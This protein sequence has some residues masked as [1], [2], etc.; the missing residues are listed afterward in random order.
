M[1]KFRTVQFGELQY[2]EA[3]VIHLP[4]GLVGMP[5]L[6]NWLILEMGDDLPLSIVNRG[7]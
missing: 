2:K 6:K 4:E 1:P 5:T 7:C 3:D